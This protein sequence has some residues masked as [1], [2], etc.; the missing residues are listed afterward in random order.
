M[1]LKNNLNKLTPK[2]IKQMTIEEMQNLATDIRKLILESVKLNG[3]HLSSN[4]GIV[5]LTIALHYVFDFSKDKL[6]FDTSHQIYPHKIITGRA[7]KFFKLRN[8]G[9]VSGFSSYNESNYDHFEAGH[10]GT[11]LAALMGYLWTDKENKRKN[12]AIIGDGSIGNGM[13]LEGLNLIGYYK[14]PGLIIINNNNMSISPNVGG[15]INVLSASLKEKQIFFNKLGYEYYEVK[16]G[17]S[18]VSLIEMLKTLKNIKKPIVLV[19]NTLKGRGYLPAMQD[20]VGVFHSYTPTNNNKYWIDPISGLLAQLKKSYDFNLIISAMSLGAKLNYFL[21]NFKD[22]TIDVGISEELA[23]TMAASIAK[24]NKKV[25]LT[26]FSSFSQRAFDQIWH[27]I[28]RPSLPVVILLEKS[29]IIPNDGS[30]HQGLLDVSIFNIMPNIEILSPSNLEEAY[31]CLNYA[32]NQDK[33]P[34]MIRF[35]NNPIYF[36]EDINLSSVKGN[37]IEWRKEKEGKKLNIITYGASLDR[38]K[39]IS[40]DYQVDANIYNALIIKPIDIKT[41]NKIFLNGFPILIIE[42]QINKSS[43]YLE[44]LKY[45]EENN[46]SNKLY[47]FSVETHDIPPYDYDDI[48]KEIK[49]DDKELINKIKDIL[50]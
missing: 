9:G 42:D 36:N 44:I 6:I 21:E 1:A 4:L 24:D 28:C 50:K 15:Q 40:Y 31:L 34:V 23:A 32:L 16:E 19:V 41:L 3:G 11:S 35:S 45:K 10:A 12:I 27:D 22:T 33:K 17:N 25:I 29:G 38:I 5:E 26:Y 2:K 43:L 8:K 39:K 47:S 49:F 48:L 13:A 30:T 46:F 7:N 14:L 20:D 37:K 18:I